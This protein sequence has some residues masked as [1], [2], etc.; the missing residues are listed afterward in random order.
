MLAQKDVRTEE[1]RRL[2]AELAE[3]DN[4]MAQAVL[5]GAPQLTLITLSGRVI[6]ALLRLGDARRGQPSQGGASW[7]SA[8]AG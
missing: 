3:A 7:E 8:G 6:T 2:E 4:D 5:A 1:C